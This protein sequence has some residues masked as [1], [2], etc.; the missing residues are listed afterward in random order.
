MKYEWFWVSEITSCRRENVWLT[1]NVMR[2]LR[3]MRETW[4]IRDHAAR[5]MQ[6]KS[7][8]K[9]LIGGQTTFATSTF[10][11]PHSPRT[12][13]RSSNDADLSALDAHFRT[14][15]PLVGRTDRRAYRLN[16]VNSRRRKMTETDD[17]KEE[18]KLRS[19]QSYFRPYRTH[20]NYHGKKNCTFLYKARRRSTHACSP[21]FEVPAFS[22]NNL[23]SQV[24]N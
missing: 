15:T 6:Q 19:N 16:E 21:L 24:M 11:V 2:V 20:K 13:P 1:L 3:R 8:R 9:L 7:K 5:W 22:V 23:V 10:S 4:Q 17:E 12:V 14:Q 18:K